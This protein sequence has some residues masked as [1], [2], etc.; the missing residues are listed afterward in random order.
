MS[1]RRGS[2]NW[3]LQELSTSLSASVNITGNV[4]SKASP[5]EK[6]HVQELSQ[7]CFDQNGISQL[8]V[9]SE[10]AK[11]PEL[12]YSCGY[13]L[14]NNKEIHIVTLQCHHILMQKL[15]NGVTPSE[16]EVYHLVLILHAL[17]LVKNCISI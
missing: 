3:G 14:N 4:C 10:E 7:A 11:F 16:L 6:A 5:E 15:E 8:S 9:L 1:R 2:T 13:A 12:H 17:G